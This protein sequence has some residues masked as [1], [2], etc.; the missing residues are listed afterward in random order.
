[1]KKVAAVFV[2][3]FG[4]MLDQAGLATPLT[5]HVQLF[6]SANTLRGSGFFTAA[7]MADA[8]SETCNACISDS[9]FDFG[10]ATWD[11][12]DISFFFYSSDSSAVVTNYVLQM[13]NSNN[14]Y[15]YICDKLFTQGCP[16]ETGWYFGST[17]PPYFDESIGADSV[18]TTVPEPATLAL[19]GLGLAALGLQGRRRAE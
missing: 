18:R 11:E 1:M 9:S 8:S 14:E 3:L 2:V 16:A 7:V 15:L 5:Y 10:G 4:T 13:H 12:T 19:F 6:D 17:E